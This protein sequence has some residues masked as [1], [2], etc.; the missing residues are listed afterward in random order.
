MH[1]LTT[2]MFDT[3]AVSDFYEYSSF[4]CN[5]SLRLID[6]TTTISAVTTLISLS[7]TMG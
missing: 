7:K 2:A 4:K 1:T 5:N 3:T 6:I